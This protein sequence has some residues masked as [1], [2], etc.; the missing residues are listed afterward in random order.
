MAILFHV[1]YVIIASSDQ[2]AIVKLKD[3]LNKVFKLKDLG[4][5]KYFLG[6][7]IARSTAGICVSQ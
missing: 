7:E 4:D 2:Q 3:D 1:D 5:L 6:L